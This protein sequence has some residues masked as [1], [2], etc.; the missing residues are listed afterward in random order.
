MSSS[1]AYNGAFSDTD[2]DYING[3]IGQYSMTLVGYI[4]HDQAWDI[5]SFDYEVKVPEPMTLALFGAGL[6]G[7]GLVSRRKRQN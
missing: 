2:S 4:T 1:G 6:I 7:L 5:S 3:L